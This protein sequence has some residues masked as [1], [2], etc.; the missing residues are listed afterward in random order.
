MGF[1][2][3]RARSSVRFSFGSGNTADEINEAVRVME[4]LAGRLREIE[5]EEQHPHSTV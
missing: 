4:V 3:E 5:F 1:S 2:K